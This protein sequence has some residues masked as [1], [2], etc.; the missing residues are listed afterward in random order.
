MFFV[1]GFCQQ[2]FKDKKSVS[3]KKSLAKNQKFLNQIGNS[4]QKLKR[5][6]FEIFVGEAWLIFV[7]LINVSL[8]KIN[9]SLYYC[10]EK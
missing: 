7:F 9:M 1:L 2:I 3:G 6:L 5:K 8:V 4:A 10:F